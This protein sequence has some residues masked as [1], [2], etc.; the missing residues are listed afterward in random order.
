MAA[1][2]PI[3]APPPPENFSQQDERKRVRLRSQQ[4]SLGM[5][6]DEQ[7]QAARSYLASLSV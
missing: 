2:R 7:P 5:S 4:S 6:I 3:I 1:T